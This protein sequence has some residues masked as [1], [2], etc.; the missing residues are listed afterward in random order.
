ML[1]PALISHTLASLGLPY[2]TADYQRVNAQSAD[3]RP[4][5]ALGYAR[6][7]TDEQARE[8][9]S[10]AQE[11]AADVKTVPRDLPVQ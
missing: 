11:D 8:G 10:L 3:R 6:V 1:M 2:V 4:R 9:V 5:T 7:S